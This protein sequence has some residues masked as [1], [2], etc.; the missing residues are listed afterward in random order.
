MQ[1]KAYRGHLE[2]PN[3]TIIDLV[4]SNDDQP[5]AQSLLK[6]STEAILKGGCK[7]ENTG[8][9]EE[10]IILVYHPTFEGGKTPLGWIAQGVTQPMTNVDFFKLHH[11]QRQAA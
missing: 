9:P 7:F 5:L 11:L 1:P 2:L 6:Q 4:N 3:R 10:P 8:T